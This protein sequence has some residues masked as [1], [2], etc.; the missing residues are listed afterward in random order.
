MARCKSAPK[1]DPTP[2]ACNTLIYHTKFVLGRSRS[3]PIGC[4]GKWSLIPVL[5]VIYYRCEVGFRLGAD[6]HRGDERQVAGRYAAIGIDG[7]SGQREIR[8]SLCG[9]GGCV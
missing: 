5:S 6:L 2:G 3:A 1:Q 4:P 7:S 9:A 8:G